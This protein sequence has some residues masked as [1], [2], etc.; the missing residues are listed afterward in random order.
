MT[1]LIIPAISTVIV[2]KLRSRI[3]IN[4]QINDDWKICWHAAK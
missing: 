4:G 2:P 3:S 1:T